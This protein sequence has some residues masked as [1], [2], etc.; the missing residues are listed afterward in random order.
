MVVVAHVV[1]VCV[2]CCC[3]A[4]VVVIAVVMVSAK[5]RHVYRLHFNEAAEQWEC[6]CVLKIVALCLALIRDILAITTAFAIFFK[7][8]S[9]LIF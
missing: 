3:C 9:D 8:P 5:R 6:V 2:Y 1:C 7:R 4:A